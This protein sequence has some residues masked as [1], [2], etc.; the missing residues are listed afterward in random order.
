MLE[1]VAKET[2]LPIDEVHMW[3]DHLKTIDTNRKRGAAKAA[4][5]RRR[6]RETLKTATTTA[7][8]TT[9]EPTTVEQE[10]ETYYCGVC[11]LIYGDSDEP[12]FWVG[13]EK[14][15]AWF[16]GS[17]INISPDNEPDE[18]FCYACV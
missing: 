10:E 18:Y 9:A 1:N 14:C 15:D 16:H 5:T 7:E 6:K 11:Q 17:C 3:L 8:P 2:L 13:C 12:E 4:E